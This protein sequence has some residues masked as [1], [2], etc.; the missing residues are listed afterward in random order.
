[1]SA[2][3]NKISEVGAND[4]GLHGQ[5]KTWFLDYASYVISGKSRTGNR[6]WIEA[7]TTPHPSC[8]EGNG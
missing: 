4:N 8:D 7:G 5:Y 2:A 1:M 6:R 3:K